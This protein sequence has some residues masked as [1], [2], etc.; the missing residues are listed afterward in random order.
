MRVEAATFLEV[1]LALC[2]VMGRALAP[3]RSGPTV[4]CQVAGTY[5]DE[6]LTGNRSRSAAASREMSD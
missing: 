6:S 2:E 3:F 5:R 4:S 1:E